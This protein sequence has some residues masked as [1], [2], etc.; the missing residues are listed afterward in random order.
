M[1]IV[2]RKF[3]WF[4]V[5]ELHGHLIFAGEADPWYPKAR[6][7]TRLVASATFF[8][9]PGIG[10]EALER[11]DFVLP[12]ISKFLAEVSKKYT[13]SCSSS[14]MNRNEYYNKMADCL[15]VTVHSRIDFGQRF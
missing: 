8:S 14:R 12:H 4:I 1:A 11:G 15:V 9:L 7:F 5:R 13:E 6:E 10:H 2:Y 3:R